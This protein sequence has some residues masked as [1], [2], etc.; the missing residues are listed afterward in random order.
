M[1]KLKSAHNKNVTLLLPGLLAGIIMPLLAW[2][3]C[4]EPPIE[5]QKQ[6]AT[7]A[8]L[9]FVYKDKTCPVFIHWMPPELIKECANFIIQHEPR[10][11]TTD[12]IK[13]QPPVINGCPIS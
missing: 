2:V 7:K 10:K 11:A 9:C 1:S 5:W 8:A 3:P 13:L 12:S 4:P 6:Q